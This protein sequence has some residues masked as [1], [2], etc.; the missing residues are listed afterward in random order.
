MF[1]AL[2]DNKIIAVNEDDYFPLMNFD[3]KEEDDDHN[4][5]DY[6]HYDGEFLLTLDIPVPTKEEQS[7][8]RAAAYLVE[9]DPI[10][11]QIQRLRDETE[12]DEE[13]IASLIAERAAK[14]LEIKT[15]YPYPAEATES[16]AEDELTE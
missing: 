8:K 13:K 11:A 1:K 4:V 12:P 15:L 10:T 3:K 9:I 2:K 6:V 7:S 5:T 16:E 14:V